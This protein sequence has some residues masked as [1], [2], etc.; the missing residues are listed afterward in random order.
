MQCSFATLSFQFVLIRMTSRA[1]VFAASQ[2]HR[3]PYGLLMAR[4]RSRNGSGRS[5]GSCRRALIRNK[6]RSYARFCCISRTNRCSSSPHITP[7]GT[8]SLWPSPSAI[9]FVR[10]LEKSWKLYLP[11]PPWR[12]CLACHKLL[13]PDL[14]PRHHG[15]LEQRELP[16]LS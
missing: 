6:P 13:L 9:H 14:S 15:A 2:E 16:P 5:K 1:F 12:T 10:F 11:Y 7:S 4:M 3:S 8:A